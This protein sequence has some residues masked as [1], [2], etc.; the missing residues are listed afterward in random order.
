MRYL[1]IAR[2]SAGMALGQDIYDGEGRMLLARHLIL[3]KEYIANL[4]EL[5]FPGVYIDDKFTA[6]IEIEEVLSPEVKCQ[7]LKLVQNFFLEESGSSK[8]EEN[9]I[10]NLIEKIVR[11]VLSDGDLM[12]NMMDLKTY[13]DYT[14]FHSVNVATLSCVIGARYKMSEDQLKL[15]TTAAMLHDIGKKFLELDIL[16]A[17]RALSDAEKRMMLQH[18][19]LGYEYLKKNFRFGMEVCEGILEH[20]EWYNGEGYPLRKSGNDISIFARIIKLAD[21]YDAMTS[22]RPYHE[23]LSPSDAV[24]Y[25]MAMNE[26]EFDP[27]MVNVF[28]R[29]V[30]VYPIGCE[31]E[32]S[33]GQRAI[34]VK[35]FHDFVLRPIVKIIDSGKT[36]NLKMDNE[37]RNITIVNM[38]A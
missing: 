1:P 8:L 21:V 7:A 25:I 3:D 27:E 37:A 19:K 6:G 28:V 14:Y 4:E 18:P 30:A 15:L 23:A 5:G 38:I 29:W 2:L 22:K 17:K 33:N 24:E 36:L 35:N 32:L 26:T 31:V 11:E 13:D 9:K 12:Y 10:R 34:V 16:N 20:H